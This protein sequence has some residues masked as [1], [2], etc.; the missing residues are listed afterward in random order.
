MLSIVYN[1]FTKVLAVLLEILVVSES[2]ASLIKGLPFFSWL[3]VSIIF[4]FFFS[5]ASLLL[6]RWYRFYL[7]FWSST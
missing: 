5:W 7:S 3:S 2:I 4:S 6:S 1:S